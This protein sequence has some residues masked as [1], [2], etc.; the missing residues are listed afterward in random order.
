MKDLG[1]EYSRLI[2]A[3]LDRLMS[4]EDRTAAVSLR[5]ALKRMIVSGIYSDAL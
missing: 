2:G 4:Y 1:Q 5:G 3:M